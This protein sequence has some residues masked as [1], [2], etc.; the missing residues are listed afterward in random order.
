V[1]N[2]PTTPGQPPVTSFM[3]A[4]APSAPAE[5]TASGAAPGALPD[6]QAMLTF[7]GALRDLRADTQDLQEAV[8]AVRKKSELEDAASRAEEI[9]TALENAQ[10]VFQRNRQRINDLLGSVRQIFQQ[11]PY[12]YDWCSDEV[13]HIEN[14][15]AKLGDRWPEA[16][17]TEDQILQNIDATHAVLQKM[18]YLC[19][20]LTIP[21]RANLHLETL[22]I[23]Q[24][25]DFHKSFQDELDVEEDRTRMLGFMADHPFIVSGV[26]DAANGVIYKASPSWRRRSLSTVMLLAVL[27]LGFG[28]V[29]IMTHMGT[30]LGIEDWKPANRFPELV[31]A[32]VFLILG[33][34]AHLLVDALKQSRENKEAALLAVH[35]WLLWLHVKES[36]LLMG[37]LYIWVGLIGLAFTVDTVQWAMAFFVGYSIDS[38][39]D[40]F[41]Q[42]FSQAVSARTEAL[43][44]DLAAG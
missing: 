34:G 31:A 20:R 2:Q 29:Y 15:W 24:V 44:E 35:D 41:L 27:A 40:L 30:W 5:A 33:A 18:I 19:G 6:S 4:P 14:C 32:Y 26:V 22:R 21:A 1:Q 43:R 38:F 37:V 9:K 13:A 10:G 42:R 23:G 28:L 7:R 3:A 11:H 12:I 17:Q 39:V 36:A 25:L 16:D 8:A